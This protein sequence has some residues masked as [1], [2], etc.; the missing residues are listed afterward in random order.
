VTV[1]DA[2]LRRGQV[3]TLAITVEVF[4]APGDGVA[5][6][7]FTDSDG[8]RKLLTIDVAAASVQ[9]LDGYVVLASVKA[10]PGVLVAQWHDTAEAAVADAAE[11]AAPDAEAYA[12]LPL[13]REPG[14]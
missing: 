9:T 14:Q 6:F 1:D 7:V 2:N 8:D 10:R 3:V 5:T 13:G 12:L 11:W 4:D